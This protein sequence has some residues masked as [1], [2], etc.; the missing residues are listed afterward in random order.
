MVMENGRAVLVHPP[1]GPPTDKCN[2]DFRARV[3][4]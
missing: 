4:K 1:D 3:L 2:S